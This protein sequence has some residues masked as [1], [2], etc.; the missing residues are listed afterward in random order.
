MAAPEDL[1]SVGEVSR[2]TGVAVSALHYYERRG[3]IASRRAP[4]GH[5]R[6]PRHML[7]R[8]SLLVIAR[9]IGVP[10]D[11]VAAALADLPPDRA[12][13]RAEWA[14]VSESWREDLARRRRAIE[15]LEAQL[16]GCIGCGCLSMDSCG[17]SNPDDA[18]GRGARGPVRVLPD[19]VGSDSPDGADGAV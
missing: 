7:R 18:L 1:L 4:S 6:Y 15:A 5:R 12:P 3:L 8:V 17:L 14:R 19:A 2:R 11:D 16:E 10:L 13:T 9:R